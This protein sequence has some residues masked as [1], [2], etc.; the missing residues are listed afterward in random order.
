MDCTEVREQL[1][2]YLDEEAREEICRAIEQHLNHCPDCRIEVDT[3]RK[4]IV[5]YQSDREVEMPVGL[6]SKLMAALSREYS[7]R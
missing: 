5:L 7:R 2:D 3:T 6:G 4:T 1:S